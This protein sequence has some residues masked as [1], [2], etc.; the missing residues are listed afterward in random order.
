MLRL[1]SG[2]IGVLGGLM[3]DSV[4]NLEDRI[5]GIGQIPVFG[6]LFKQK[7]DVNRKTELVIFLRAVILN[8]P[9]IDGDLRTRDFFRK[10]DP[11]RTAPPILPG[12]AT[13]Q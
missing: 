4:E 8:D 3:Q 12:A 11:G 9:S 13:A 7:R 6:E 2:E 1:Q 5:P 10:P